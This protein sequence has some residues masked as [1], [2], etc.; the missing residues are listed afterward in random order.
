MINRVLLWSLG[1][2]PKR[3]PR[4][5]GRIPQKKMKIGI[6]KANPET[7]KFGVNLIIQG[8][9]NVKLAVS[10]SRIIIALSRRVFKLIKNIIK[11]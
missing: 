6:N 1:K 8:V 4:E 5:F 7:V 3:V 9:P 10:I 2:A 11:I